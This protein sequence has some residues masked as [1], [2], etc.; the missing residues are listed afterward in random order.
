MQN[1][2]P[3]DTLNRLLHTWPCFKLVNAH[4]LASS[5]AQVCEGHVVSNKTFKAH[6][7]GITRFKKHSGDANNGLDRYWPRPCALKRVIPGKCDINIT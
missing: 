2:S 5:R 7:P 6:L 1:T 4:L 3:D